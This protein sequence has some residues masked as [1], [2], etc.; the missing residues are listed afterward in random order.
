MTG[1]MYFQNCQKPVNSS[2]KNLQTNPIL[3]EKQNSKPNKVAHENS[4]INYTKIC[5][6]VK[7]T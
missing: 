5:T 6:K 3:K 1:D 4:F 7:K 2:I